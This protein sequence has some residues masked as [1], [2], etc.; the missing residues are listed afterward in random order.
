[1]SFLHL[2]EVGDAE[3]L[4]QN[5]EVYRVFRKGDNGQAYPIYRNTVPEGGIR[6][7][8]LALDTKA[9]GF[10]AIFDKLNSPY[11][12]DD[13]SEHTRHYIENLKISNGI[14]SVFL[15]LA[16]FGVKILL[17]FV[18]SR[19]CASVGNVDRESSLNAFSKAR[20]FPGIC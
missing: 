11:F 5:I 10:I 14:D 15:S 18:R 6:K 9:P 19:G 1:M 7:N 3:G 12:L 20:A 2:G 13:S 16:G 17:R 4:I 8:S